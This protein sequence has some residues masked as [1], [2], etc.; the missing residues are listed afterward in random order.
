MK[1]FGQDGSELMD[2]SAIERDG[3]KLLVRGKVFSAMPMVASL[4][5]AE[6][7]NLFKL[8]DFRTLLFILSLP[9]R[10]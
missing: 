6:A 2:V 10:K 5:P 3:D 4:P 7:R 9:F 8:I 1:L